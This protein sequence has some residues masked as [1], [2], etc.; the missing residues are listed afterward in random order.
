MMSRKCVVLVDNSNV[1]IG[2]RKFSARVKGVTEGDG[3]HDEPCDPSWRLNFDELLDWLAD[4]RTIHQA[5]MV[6]SGR[7]DMDGI[8][9]PARESGFEVIVYDRR[10]GGEKAVDTELVAQ[11]TEIIATAEEPMTLV[12]AS[13]DL[14]FLPLMNVA[15]R[16]EWQTELCA[17]STDFDPRGE[18][19]NSVDRVR[20]LDDAFLTIGRC[21]WDWPEGDGQGV[22]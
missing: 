16:H 3:K 17:F 6:G 7:P 5:I 11:G 12:L 15:Q 2:G 20:V 21:E 14:D 8:W 22:N 18:L 9:D 13:G 10:H 4:G 19:A 1:F